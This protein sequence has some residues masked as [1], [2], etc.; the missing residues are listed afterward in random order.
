MKK[1][2]GTKYIAELYEGDTWIIYN[3]MILIANPDRP[4]RM[5]SKDGKIIE[6][7]I[8]KD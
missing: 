2:Q 3:D 7:P 4:L 6:I 1:R 8:N 5:I